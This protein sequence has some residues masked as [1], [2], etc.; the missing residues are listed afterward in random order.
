[1]GK[2][3]WS[4]LSRLRTAV[5]KVKILLNLNLNRW[6]IASMIGASSSNR[7]FSFNDRPGLKAA[8]EEDMESTWDE[9][10][11]VSR[12][13][14]SLHRTISWPSEQDDI[15]K[16]AEMFIANFHKQ[17]QIER[18]ISLE[19]RYCRGNSSGSTVSP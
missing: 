8:T 12:S 2:N 14:S 4:L 6:R 5:K 3:S 13:G 19:L 10:S 9:S 1:M 7:F 17:L 18:Q 16:R 11:S 15:D